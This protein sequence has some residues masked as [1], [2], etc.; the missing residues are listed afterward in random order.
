MEGLPCSL[1]AYRSSKI[2][3]FLSVP[4]RLSQ[5]SNR[6]ALQSRFILWRSVSMPRYRYKSAYIVSEKFFRLRMIQV[7]TISDGIAILEALG[8]G[9]LMVST[10]RRS[11]TGYP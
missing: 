6:A 7:H 2:L 4:F 1:A 9:R 8:E 11:P 3:S 5:R 10:Q